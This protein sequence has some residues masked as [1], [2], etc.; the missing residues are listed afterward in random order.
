MIALLLGAVGVPDHEIVAD[1][2]LTTDYIQ[3]LLP[4]LR[5]H[6]GQNRHRPGTL[7]ADARLLAGLMAGALQHIREKYGNIPAY[8]K[9]VGFTDEDLAHLRNMLVTS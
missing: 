7:R 9:Q 3:L 1:Y 6:A 2:A 4:E 5:G 8:L